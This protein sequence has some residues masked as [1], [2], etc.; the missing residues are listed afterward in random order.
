VTA[1]VYVAG[2]QPGYQWLLADDE[3]D[4]ER[5]HAIATH[6]PGEA[7]GPPPMHLLER[8][9]DGTILEPADLPWLVSMTLAVSETALRTV[10]P[11]LEPYGEF[12]PV[13]GSAAGY[14]LF[15]GTCWSDALDEARSEL[16]RFSDGGIMRIQNV[17]LAT[18]AFDQ[19]EVIRLHQTPRGPLYFAASL[20]ERI[21]ALGLTGTRFTP[22]GS[23]SGSPR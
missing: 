14:Q 8:T 7:W 3:A 10:R 19:A 20:V 9:E 22:R 21:K 23:L 2:P 11:L 5:V 1:P 15:N 4:Y 16:A 17:V 12:L 6:R 13:G 18:D